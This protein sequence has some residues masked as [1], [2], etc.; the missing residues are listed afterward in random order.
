LNH[1][2]SVSVPEGATSVT[3]TTTAGPWDNYPPDN[4]SCGPDGYSLTQSW[5]LGA[6]R[7]LANEDDFVNSA[8]NSSRIKQ[9][10]YPIGSLVVLW[11]TQPTVTINQA[12]N[13]TDPT[14]AWPI[15]F[16]VVFSEPVTDFTTGDVML[17][18][19]AGA[20]TAIVTGSGTTYNVAVS[21]MTGSG[22]VIPTIAAG[23]AHGSINN[24][25]L[26]STSDDSTV[27]YDAVLPVVVS[28]APNI[29]L[30]TDA[31]VGSATFLLTIV[32]SESMDTS[33]APTI[34]F[35]VEDP[36]GTLT[37]NTTSSGWIN[38]T[39]YVAAYNVVDANIV[40]SNVDVGVAAAT[41][42]AKNVQVSTTVNNVFNINTV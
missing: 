16:T 5:F 3:I 14:N 13:Q 31:N 28:V 4:L 9:G 22:T 33:T 21:G 17:S 24:A 36:T 20:T 41:D 25:N 29:V 12:A 39:T 42:V 6:D 8:M 11:D 7:A 23:V 1:P 38:S 34:T 40:L 32:Y 2:T 18:G 19:T 15:N 35:P 10:E 26:A 37:R 30:I 27:V